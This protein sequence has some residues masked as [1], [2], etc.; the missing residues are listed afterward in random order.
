MIKYIKRYIKDLD[1][2]T[3]LEYKNSDKVA[4]ATLINDSNHLSNLDFSNLDLQGLS[5]ENC[6][7]YNCKF[8]NSYLFLAK[9]KGCIFT[10]CNFEG[11]TL[12]SSNILGGEFVNCNFSEAEMRN[13]YFVKSMIKN[14][15]FHN[16][17]MAHSKLLYCDF[18]Y[19]NLE[20]A[21]TNNTDWHKTIIE[22][23]DLHEQKFT[24][25]YNA[26]QQEVE[27]K[28]TSATENDS[29]SDTG[30][31]ANKTN[32]SQTIKNQRKWKQQRT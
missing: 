10:N 22:N 3:I 17:Y 13:I 21:N 30:G 24:C 12:T 4:I 15:N 28:T 18:K 29:R 26:Y 27:I 16:T 23:K 5:I 11:T 6:R 14:C 31:G 9:I 19:N 25:V 2:N 32:L 8:S 20:N 7:F 1:G